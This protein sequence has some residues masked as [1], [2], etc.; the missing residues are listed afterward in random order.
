MKN[1]TDIVRE[2]DLTEV[3]KRTG[4]VKDKCDKAKWRTPL[5][6]ISVTGPKFMNWS[7]GVG[8]G[9][10][11]DLIIHLKNFDFKTAVFW[12]SDNFPSYSQTSPEINSLQKSH[13]MLP[14]RDDNKLSGVMNY[15]EHRRGIPQRIINQLISSEKLYADYRGNAVFLLLGKEKKAVGAELRGTSDLRWRGMAQGSKKSRGF[16]YIRNRDSKQIILCESAI[17]AI[18]YFALQPDCLALSTSGANPNPA[19]LPILIKRGFKIFCGFDSNKPGDII[20]KKM[21]G[22]YPSVKRLRP[23][24]NDWND[25]LRSKAGLV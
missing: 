5:G 25:V 7:Q 10:A 23:N 1:K 11:I 20:A 6:V 21:I 15:L 16:F 2:I 18:S 14:R 4:A 13:L 12:L 9:G 19:W 17:D 3:L 22:H 8:G 24:K